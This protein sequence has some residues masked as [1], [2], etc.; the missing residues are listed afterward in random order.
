ML[1]EQETFKEKSE[2]LRKNIEDL[3]QYDNLDNLSEYASN[4]RSLYEEMESAL[5]KA[6]KFN[7][8]EK[9]FNVEEETDYNFLKVYKK[10]FT[11]YKDF[12]IT[13][14]EWV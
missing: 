11:W 8:R 2:E 9:L 4:I 3:S 14:D 5:L 1:E 10:D 7:E 6:D 13:I 12:W